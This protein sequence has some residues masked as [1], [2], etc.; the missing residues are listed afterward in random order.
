MMRRGF[1]VDGL[2]LDSENLLIRRI[3][4]QPQPRTITATT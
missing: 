4:S 1:R 3:V 2:V